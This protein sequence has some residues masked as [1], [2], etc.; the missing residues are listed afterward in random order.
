MD[1]YWDRFD[2][3]LKNRDNQA[4]RE[5]QGLGP[6]VTIGTRETHRHAGELAGNRLQ[7]AHQPLKWVGPSRFL[8][9]PYAR[10]LAVRALGQSDSSEQTSVI[11]PA[12]ENEVTSPV[13]KSNV[14]PTRPTCNKNALLSPTTPN[15]P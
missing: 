6:F 7:A 10:G 9:Q 11:V 4:W 3:A 1:A 14:R 2:R 12:Q 15:G 13:S 5:E 8:R